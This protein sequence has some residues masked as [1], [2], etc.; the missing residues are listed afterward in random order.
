MSRNEEFSVKESG[1]RAS[2]NTLSATVL[3]TEL[4][5]CAPGTPPVTI[6]DL[7]IAAGSFD[8]SAGQYLEVLH[9]SGE[10]IPLSIAS[11]PRRLPV[12]RLHYRSMPGAPGAAAMDEL[13]SSAENGRLRLKIRG[14]SGSIRVDATETQRVFL[15][16]GGTGTAQAQSIAETLESAG[17]DRGHLLLACADDDADFYCTDLFDQ[18]SC[19]RCHFIAD[20]DRSPRN[21]CLCWLRER[22]VGQMPARIIASGSPGF[23]YAVTDTLLELGIA[24]HSIESDVFAYAPR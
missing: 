5:L 3:R 1:T 16:T 19:L 6:L 2:G 21:R 8:F 7:E 13:L 14:P 18:L 24:K 23:V 20:A 9:P 15:I 11:T 12:L 22:A 4:R 17:T 10:S